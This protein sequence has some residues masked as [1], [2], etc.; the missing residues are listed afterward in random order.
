MR[1]SERPLT[2][3]DL[4]PSTVAGIARRRKSKT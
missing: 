2:A 4:N 1:L 3:H